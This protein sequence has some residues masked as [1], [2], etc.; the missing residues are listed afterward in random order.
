MNAFFKLWVNGYHWVL[1]CLISSGMASDGTLTFRV[2]A[3]SSKPNFL[4]IIADDCTYTDLGV[5]GGQAAT[6]HLSQLAR[7]GVMFSRCFQ[8]APMCSP[9][10]HCLYTGIYPVKSGA[11]PNHTF[12][13]PGTRSIAH[14]LKEGGYRVALSGKTHI[15]PPESFPFEY[16]KAKGGGG[17]NPDMDAIDALF[18]DAADTGQPVA[19]FA[20][21]NEPH[22]P[23][24]KGD[25][26][27]YPPDQ[28]ELP[29][30]FVDTPEVRKAFSNYLAEVT[31]FDGQ[32]GQ[33]LDLLKKHGLEGN[34]LVMVVSEQGNSFPFAKWTCYDK[35]LQS[36]MIVRWPGRV[37]PGT[38][39]DAMVEYVDVV[40]TF[41]QAAGLPLP[42]VLDGQ[43]FVPVLRGWTDQHKQY[44]FGLQTTRGINQG[45]DYYGIR[46][47]RSD[48][49]RY[50]RNLTPESAFQNTMMNSG[51][52]Q[53]WMTKAEGGS[54]HAQK[55]VYRFQHRPA[56][57]LYDS[58]N[59]PWNLENLSDH[60][61]FQSVKIQLSKALDDWMRDQ[62]DGGQ[63]TELDA[64]HRQW[65][66]RER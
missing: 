25:A 8:A 40:P 42:H 28:L 3:S 5:Y 36:G 35:G 49:F 60:P 33:C 14:Y 13:K 39:T 32:V 1:V 18:K 2:E 62:G 23:H 54:D 64:L 29:P 52:W 31:Y 44:S 58:E 4:F 47:V 65:R 27:A 12:V 16:S 6:P 46:S 38:R 43:S 55:V 63:K 48:R 57:E 15:N 66:N 30:H 34:T 56:E 7:E 51:W 24:N 21:S 9:T 41:L 11:H 50:I 17:G 10:R 59:D 20:C 53:S 37:K 45:S 61:E 22:T 19:L 26:S